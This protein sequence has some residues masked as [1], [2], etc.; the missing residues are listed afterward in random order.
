MLSELQ[1]VEQRQASLWDDAAAE[2]GR[3]RARKLMKVL[4]AVNG[5][6]GRGGPAAGGTGQQARVDDEARP[7]VAAIHHAVGRCSEGGRALRTSCANLAHG[8]GRIIKCPR[9]DQSRGSNHRKG[10]GAEIG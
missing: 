10:K 5:R 8:V 6:F 9:P 7:G 1:R 2:D 4:D 3:E